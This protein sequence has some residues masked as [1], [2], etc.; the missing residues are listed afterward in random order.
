[1]RPDRPVTQS[2][3]ITDPV[4]GHNLSGGNRRSDTGPTMADGTRTLT[5]FTGL[6]CYWPGADRWWLSS[7][8]HV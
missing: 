4:E 8:Y 6:A 3:A 1:M 2:I 5:I 7:T